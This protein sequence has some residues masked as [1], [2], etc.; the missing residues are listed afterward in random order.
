MGRLLPSGTDG[1]IGE[2]CQVRGRSSVRHDKLDVAV[3]P[4]PQGL[5]FITAEAE[6]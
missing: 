6:S 1:D 2:I 3:D 4:K 5:S